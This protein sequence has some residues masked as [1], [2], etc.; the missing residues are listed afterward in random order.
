MIEYIKHEKNQTIIY[1]DGKMTIM[2]QSVLYVIHQL[3]IEH[4]TTY[5]GYVK[6]VQSKYHRHHL[7]PVVLSSDLML[8]PMMRI[9]TYEN[10]WVN[11]AAIQSIHST[12]HG[13]IITFFGLNQLQINKNLS[14]FK[15]A[16]N[17]VNMIKNEKVKHFHT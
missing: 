11:S 7:I 6:A 2:N 13:V 10:I 1:Q 14:Y 5:E 12:N 16:I 4:L 8:I 15:K 17:F 3:C 9:R